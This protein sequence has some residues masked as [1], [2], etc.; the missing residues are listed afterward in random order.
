MLNYLVF[1]I[2][3]TALMSVIVYDLVIAEVSYIQQIFLESVEF[4]KTRFK[5]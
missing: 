3:V 5:R 1:F 4:I 2:T